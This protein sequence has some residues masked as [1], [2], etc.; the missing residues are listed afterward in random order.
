MKNQQVIIS[1]EEFENDVKELVNKIPQG[2]FTKIVAIAKGGLI[3]AY[4]LAKFLFI[5]RVETINIQSYKDRER[6]ELVLT[7]S[8]KGS[9][10]KDWLIVDDL[11]DSGHTAQLTKK[12]YPNSQLAVIYKKP[13]SIILP[14]YFSKEM[15][16]WIVFPWEV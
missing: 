15:D 3:P 14:E 9:L 5:D 12:L 10:E 16:K 8:K 2:K 13:N 1:W 6:G 4:Y 11:V 7:G